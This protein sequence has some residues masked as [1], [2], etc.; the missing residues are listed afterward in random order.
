[1]LDNVLRTRMEK[2]KQDIEMCNFNFHNLYEEL[3]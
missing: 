1:M 3:N 2:Q